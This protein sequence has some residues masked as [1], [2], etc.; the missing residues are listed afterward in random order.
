MKQKKNAFDTG[1]FLFDWEAP[2]YHQHKRGWLWYV[3]FCLVFFGG[4]IFFILND[5]EWGWL[6]AFVFFASAA[7]YFWK[8]LD[9]SRTHTIQI[10]EK[11]IVIGE[12][13]FALDLFEGFW[14]VFDPS[15]AVINFEFKTKKSGKISLQ[16]G[17]NHPDFFRDNFERINFVELE[18]K[19]ESLFDLWIRALKL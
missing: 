12:K 8:H 18:D 9:Q 14:F 10:F 17:D 16:M 7:I 5:P 15:V 3:L 13:F 4:G 6:P 1:H 19:K 11:G 2:D